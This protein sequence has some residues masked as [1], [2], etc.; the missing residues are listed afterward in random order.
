MLKSKKYFSGAIPV[1]YLPTAPWCGVLPLLI[2]FRF[3]SSENIRGGHHAFKCYI[4]SLDLINN[5]YI[6]KEELLFLIALYDLKKL[7]NHP[8]L[9]VSQKSSETWQKSSKNLCVLT[10]N[11]D[12]SML[13]V[14]HTIWAQ[15]LTSKSAKKLGEGPNPHSP[16]SE[17][18][19]GQRFRIC[20]VP[21]S[22]GAINRN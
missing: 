3:V 21:R 6:I 19:N 2:Y 18:N 14:I 8:R 22:P 5:D 20:W 4:T 16:A 11:F 17:E 13:L 10:R 12:L 1:V 9:T 7:V 15:T